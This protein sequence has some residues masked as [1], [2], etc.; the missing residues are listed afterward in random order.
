MKAL[1]ELKDIIFLTLKYY[2]ID[3]KTWKA[4]VYNAKRIVKGFK[5]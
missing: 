4:S 2:F 1:R 5:K 3:M